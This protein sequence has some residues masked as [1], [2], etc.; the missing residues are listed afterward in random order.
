MAVS[1]TQTGDYDGYNRLDMIERVMWNLG[2]VNG[3]TISYSRFPKTKVVDILNEVVRDIC[4]QIPTIMKICIVNTTADRGWYKC[5]LGCLPEGI[6][7]AYYYTSTDDY[8][9][10]E[11]WDRRKL[12]RERPGWR[13]ASSGTPEIIVPGPLYGNRFTFEVYPAPDTTGSWDTQPTGVYLGG[14]PNTMTTSVTGIATGGGASALIDSTASFRG[15]HGIVE[16]MPV[17]NVTENSYSFVQS[18]SAT[19]ISTVASLKLADGT[20][21]GTFSGGG[22]SYEIITDFT[23]VVS[24]WDD[25]DELYIFS[26]E[27]GTVSDLQP[28]ANNILLEYYSYPLNMGNDTAYPPIPRIFQDAAIDLATARL[29]RMGHEKTRQMELADRYETNGAARLAP[30]IGTEMGYPF[31]DQ[32]QRL[33]VKL[34]MNRR[35]YT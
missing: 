10:L 12:D 2:Q 14:Q 18:V 29:A 11:I 4:T 23:G 25:D 1:I 21:S 31:K 34:N 30:F 24:A 32:E 20:A 33:G 8:D 19:R 27:L 16:G 28:Q 17:W 5:P 9:E 3:T 13:T 15:Y 6:H 26:A 7:K 22:D 35:R